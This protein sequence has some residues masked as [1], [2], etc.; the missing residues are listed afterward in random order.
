MNTENTIADFMNS[1]IDNTP[2]PEI[3]RE[4]FEI[5]EK[6]ERLFGHFVPREMVPD[7]ITDE[8]IKEAMKRCIETGKD[9]LFEL[10]GITVNADYLY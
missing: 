10:L 1:F 4:Y 8:K 7:S 2:N 9:T 6:Y 5:E 3:D